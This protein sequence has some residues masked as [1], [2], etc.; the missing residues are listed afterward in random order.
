[1][2]LAKEMKQESKV[3]RPAGKEPSSYSCLQRGEAALRRGKV[4][5][6]GRASVKGR[7]CSLGSRYVVIKIH[8]Y[9]QTVCCLSKLA[10]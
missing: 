5:R 8:I 1:M 9:I 6:G 4:G 2:A 10:T 3:G 7:C